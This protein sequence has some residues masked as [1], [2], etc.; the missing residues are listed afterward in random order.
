MDKFILATTFRSERP[1]YDLLSECM[2]GR[3][4]VKGVLTA[5][6]E[7]GAYEGDDVCTG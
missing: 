7:V 2:K 3:W 6:E 4:Q 1:T 5:G